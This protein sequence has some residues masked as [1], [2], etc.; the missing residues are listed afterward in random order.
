MKI[1][2]LRWERKKELNDKMKELK[3][4]IE[5]HHGVFFLTNIRRHHILV[6]ETSYAFP[7]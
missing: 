5:E 3:I 1:V 6:V 2:C 4:D 7:S